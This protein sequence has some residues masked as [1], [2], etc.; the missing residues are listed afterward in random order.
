MSF[1]PNNDRENVLAATDLVR[2]IGE[3][4]NLRPKGKEFVGLCPFHDDKTPSM[5][6][7]PQKQI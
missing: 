3:Q 2:L 5:Y 6:V 7:S 1:T 4:V